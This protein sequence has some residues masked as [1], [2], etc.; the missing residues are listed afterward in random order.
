[1]RGRVWNRDARRKLRRFV[2]SLDCATAEFAGPEAELRFLAK[3]DAA[4][5]E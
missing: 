5:A 3:R 1:M 2:V 4:A